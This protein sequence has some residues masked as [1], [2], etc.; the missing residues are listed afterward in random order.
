MHVM[1]VWF[2]LLSAKHL[3]SCKKK[4]EK[5]ADWSGFSARK[6]RS[7]CHIRRVPLQLTGAMQNWAFS[8]QTIRELQ[9]IY[10]F[11]ENSQAGFLSRHTKVRAE[12]VKSG[13]KMVLNWLWLVLT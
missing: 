5:K 7:V 2:L 4:R 12:E 8:K 11:Q 13:N 6:I 9:G 10:K 3:R 1:R